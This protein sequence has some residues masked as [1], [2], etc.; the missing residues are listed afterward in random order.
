MQLVVS[1]YGQSA[2]AQSTA[3][4]AHIVIADGKLLITVTNSTQ[5][6]DVLRN[7]LKGLGSIPGGGSGG[8]GSPGGPG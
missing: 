4:A 3:K 7:G 2:I 5:S 8:P 6:L 1:G